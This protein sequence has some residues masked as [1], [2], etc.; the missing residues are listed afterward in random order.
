MPAPNAT[1]YDAIVVGSG[2]NGLTA[3][4]I[5]ARQGW[6]V[7][8]VE[9][10]PQPGG[11]TRSGEL[12]LP[13]YVHDLCSAIHPTGVASPIFQEL[14]LVAEGLEWLHPEVALAH[15]LD[16][17]RAAIL[18][19]CLETTAASLGRDALAY[20]TLFE[21]LT[22]TASQLF[23]DVFSPLSLPR[24]PLL[25]ARFGLR[26]LPPASLLARVAF[27][28]D[29]ARALFAGNAAHSVLPLE[30]PLTSAIG[31]MLQMTAHAVGWPVA[32][33]GSQAIT[34]ALL[35]LLQR[36]GGEIVTGWRVAS[37]QEL[38]PSRAVLFDTPPR[39]LAQL[40]GDALPNG[41]R[42][43]LLRY[44]HGPGV[45]KVDYALSEPVPWTHPDCRRAG[46]VHVGGSLEEIARSE[47]DACNG[48]HSEQP[49]VLVAQQSLCDPSRAPAGRHTL[50]AY[51]HVP[52]G[53]TVDMR[54]R[55]ERQIER[56]APGFRDTILA[57]QVSNTRSMEASNPNYIGGDVI[58]GMT[59]WRQLLT[60]PVARLDPWS[61]PNPRLFLCSASTPP[62]A[63][64]HGMCG[65]HA[66]RSV[67]RRH[68]I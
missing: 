45:F 20:H 33:G 13:G 65:A 48:H 34:T 37:L 64:V 46:T 35:R 14:D 18:H 38:P 10:A 26:A 7:L 54:D 21:P 39:A 68:S 9:A 24:H 57:A 2:P 19:R 4:V 12:T 44:R 53:S 1:E 67:L 52:H 6:K 61:T 5:L 56:F 36:H 60:R 28:T 41:Y 3:A 42:R 40:A 22:A 50:W 49:F 29:E 51:C 23:P 63:G 31:L 58:G 27:R 16:H 30:A 59:D 43:R 15:P 17:G 66:A 25:M 47:Y 11:G 62:A 32:R 55:L 8:V